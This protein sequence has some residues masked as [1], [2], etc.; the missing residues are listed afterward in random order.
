MNTIRVLHI[1][2]GSK[3]FGGV[4][5]FCLNIYRKIDRKL[6]QFDFLT[7][8]ITTYEQY[9]AE[10]EGYGGKI[11]QL[12]INASTTIGKAK[13]FFAL[14]KFF[15][16]HQYDIIHINSGVLLFNCV[17]K[18]ACRQ[19][20]NA[21]IFVHSHSNGGRAT[22]KELFSYPLKI[23]LTMKTD[24]LLACSMSA[25]EYMFPRNKLTDVII[26]NNG[27][28]T[29]KFAYD[30]V[31]RE[32]LRSEMGL[33][34]KY[35][36]GHV[37]RFT[38]EKNHKFLIDLLKEIRKDKENAFLMLIG[39]GPL[40][41]SIRE[42]ADIQG[43][44]EAVLFLGAR[45][46]VK[47]LYQVMDVFVL[48]STIEGFGIVNIEAETSGLKCV[49]S[50]VVPETVNVTGNVKRLSLNDSIDMWKKEILTLSL[51]RKDMSSI[52]DNEGFSIKSA[53][54][55]VT[56]LYISCKQYKNIET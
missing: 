16:E 19:F 22:G 2:A 41:G 45:K 53:A 10:I 52:V 28:D 18:A 8:N 55:K 15:R 37:G 43:V 36:I 38:K 25:A 26:I 20:S 21:K 3:I 13:L 48:P 50:D 56:D 29:Q 34:D 35:V 30:P 54:I 9:R 49:V 1:N 31:K 46:D 11:Y 24:A 17:V 33:S 32:I 12:G 42:Y 14:R 51:D 23:Y 44:S 7:P 4:S 39:E 27:I 47:D 40:L 6:V 5:S